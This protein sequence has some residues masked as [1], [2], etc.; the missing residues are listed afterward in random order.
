MQQAKKDERRAVT[1]EV[2]EFSKEFKN[3]AGQPKGALAEG[4]KK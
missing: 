2:Q 1:E 3:T 4:R